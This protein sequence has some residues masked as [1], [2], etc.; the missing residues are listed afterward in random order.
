MSDALRES[1]DDLLRH[2][3]WQWVV[4]QARKDWAEGYG[5]K[6]KTAIQTAKANGSDV[7]AAVEAIDKAS[8]EVNIVLSRPREELARLTPKKETDMVTVLSRGG[9]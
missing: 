4:E 8:D 9:L 2:P 7:A 6:V 5:R 3:G 1:L